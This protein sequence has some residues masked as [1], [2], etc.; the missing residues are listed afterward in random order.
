MANW[1]QFL[2]GNLVTLAAFINVEPAF[3]VSIPY[4][5]PSNPAGRKPWCSWFGFQFLIGNLVTDFAQPSRF[6]RSLFQFLIGN[7]VTQ[8][9]IIA[10]KSVGACFNSL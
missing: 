4:R 9:F 3:R 8:A 6:A 5:K 2:I 7:L 1:F 10:S